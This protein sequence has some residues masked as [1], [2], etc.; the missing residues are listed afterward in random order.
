MMVKSGL[1]IIFWKFLR[2]EGILLHKKEVFVQHYKFSN[3]NYIFSA[4][5]V[6]KKI[7]V[8]YADTI[9]ETLSQKFHP[10]SILAG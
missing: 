3:K 10:Y 9:N 6:L 4:C 1:E 8:W 2:A 5:R 7:F